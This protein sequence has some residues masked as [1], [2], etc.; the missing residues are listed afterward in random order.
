MYSTADFSVTPR[1]IYTADGRKFFDIHSWP[2][3]IRPKIKQELGE[4]PFA[5]FWGPA[6]GVESP[7]GSRTA[8]TDW[9]A[10]SALWI[11]QEHGPTLSLV[12]LPHLDY[13]LQRFGPES[14]APRSRAGLSARRSIGLSEG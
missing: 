13:N 1:P 11:E 5:G 3:S 9:I 14:R 6:A 12:Y 10:E 8:A 2:Y 4:F 7:Q